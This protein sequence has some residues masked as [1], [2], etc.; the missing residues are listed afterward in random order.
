LRYSVVTCAIHS[1]VSQRLPS[2]GGAL[3]LFFAM[4]LTGC[5]PWQTS[6]TLV[7]QLHWYPLAVS[8]M[9]S[10]W[11][12]SVAEALACTAV[13]GG[14]L[15][16]EAASNAAAAT[17]KMRGVFMLISLMCGDSSSRSDRDGATELRNGE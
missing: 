7:A 1:P 4:V 2:A 14:V 11:Q 9:R 6:R 10:L 8:C 13:D 16:Q 15:A 17:N 5:E 12:Y 3:T